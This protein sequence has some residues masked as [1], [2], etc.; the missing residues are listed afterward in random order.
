MYKN[1]FPFTAKLVLS[2]RK[3]YDGLKIDIVLYL[4]YQL[5]LAGVHVYR[6]M[7]FAIRHAFDQL[8][9][10]RQSE[11]IKDDSDMSPLSRLCCGDWPIRRRGDVCARGDEIVTPKEL[12]ASASQ[13]PPPRNGNGND[14]DNVCIGD[15]R[16]TM[17]EDGRHSPYFKH[18]ICTI[19]N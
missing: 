16:R 4:R 15:K 2:Y 9:A 5:I 12:T 19:C 14:N 17:H 18:P 10:C 7:Q 1:V 13:C 8:T 11:Y 6:F 3:Q